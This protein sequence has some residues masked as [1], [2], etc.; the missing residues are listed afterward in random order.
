VQV[1]LELEA[2][3]RLESFAGENSERKT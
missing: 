2:L 1:V 3:E